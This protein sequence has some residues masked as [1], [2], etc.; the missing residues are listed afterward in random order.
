MAELKNLL[1]NGVERIN[2]DL[3]VS[4]NI[5]GTASNAVS[6][7]Y[8]PSSDVSTSYAGHFTPSGSTTK[9]VTAGQAVVGLVMDGKG[10]VTA[11]SGSSNFTA[12][13]ATSASKAVS[14]SY[15]TSASRAISASRADSAASATSATT[16][17][18]NADG[19]TAKSWIT[20]NSG[21]LNSATA[22]THTHSNKSVLDGIDSLK[23]TGWNDAYGQ[24]YGTQAHGS[25]LQAIYAKVGLQEC[26]PT[27]I[28]TVTDTRTAAGAAYK[29][30]T[31]DTTLTHGRVV[32]FITRYAGASNA[33]LELVSGSSTTGA[34]PVYF[35]G[36]TRLGTQYPANSLIFLVYDTASS[37][38]RVHADYNTNTTY[39][40]NV[41]GSA[42]NGYTT[43][44]NIPVYAKSASGSA[45]QEIMD[46]GISINDVALKSEI[47]AS[48]FIPGTGYNSAVLSGSDAEAIGWYSFAHG[49][50]TVMAVG[51]SSH[52]EGDY[53]L[54]KGIAAHAEGLGED[55]E[56]TSSA[57]IMA[58]G[59][60]SHAE[61]YSVDFTDNSFIEARG[62]GS[63]AE[64]VAKLGGQI[65]AGNSG[66]HAEGYSTDEAI[67]QTEGQGAHAG[68]YSF[69]TDSEIKAKG[70]GSFARGASVGGS[71]IASGSGT[72]A[73]GYADTSCSILAS[74]V[75]SQ[76]FGYA[77]NQF[78][79]GKIKALGAG[80]HAE[81]Y[82]LGDGTIQAIG[83]GAHA[84][85]CVESLQDGI[86]EAS[87]T[88]SHAEG[89]S[90]L[91]QN[92]AAHAEGYMTQATGRASHA[93]GNE[94]KASGSNS[95]AEGESS[96][97]KGRN[98]HVEGYSTSAEG[99]N[100]HAEGIST[101]AAGS[102][103]HAEGINRYGS[104][105]ILASGVASHV[106]GYAAGA[107]SST[108]N[109][110]GS[111]K[112]SGTGSHAGGIAL[113][114]SIEASGDGAFARGYVTYRNADNDYPAAKGIITASGIGSHAEGYAPGGLISATGNGAHA[115]GYSDIQLN[116][117]SIRAEGTGSHAEGQG[118]YAK[119]NHSHAEGQ[120]QAYGEF[121]HA[122]GVSTTYGIYSHAEGC[123]TEAS[124]NYSHAEGDW[125]VSTGH[126]SHAE[127]SN[128]VAS[129]NYSHAEGYSTHASGNYAHAEGHQT[130]AQGAY[131]HTQGFQTT[132]SGVYEFAA[133]KYNVAAANGNGQIFSIGVG[134]ANNA[135]LNAMSV[136]TSSVAASGSVKFNV[137]TAGPVVPVLDE[138]YDGDISPGD[139]DIVDVYLK[140]GVFYNLGYID[141]EEGGRVRI[142]R[143]VGPSVGGALIW[144]GVFY[145]SSPGISIEFG[146][147][148]SEEELLW[149]ENTPSLEPESFYEFSLMSDMGTTRGILVKWTA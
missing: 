15:A 7:A 59:N 142:N 132:A 26:T 115:E 86:T 141:G 138:S 53:T 45:P 122:E 110:T 46:S 29:G 126:Y 131:S 106:E 72:L 62:I 36:T 82:A 111:I 117:A 146:R 64:G 130:R 2:G 28:E 66:S 11:V 32:A 6:A 75:G 120:G 65:I 20:S 67:I 107:V 94:T 3:F 119:G 4:G 73:G 43:A 89:V 127:G 8:A 105:G 1:V 12:S 147:I 87:G 42:F 79:Q 97:A 22:S 140:P 34:K 99:D 77:R 91:A 121:S 103:S 96:T 27:L 81:G 149:P 61:G 133:G 109:F 135:R 30:N 24:I 10:H 14:A 93:E 116:N 139:T 60:G 108:T 25:Q 95:H 134:T 70:A 125:S 83:N 52:A 13:F 41:S 16:A 31:V 54:A 112:A 18:Y 145:L 102:G 39:A 85:G 101:K 23:V 44:S 104:S 114:G 58:T 71:L 80:A 55:Y 88:G 84:E 51:N 78:G 35:S 129:G 19:A 128:T 74:G 21:N 100:S 124:G 56:G 143:T 144:G 5:L 57:S 47:V 38:W 37:G 68:G 63:H 123:G 92:Y 49:G 113:S 136:Y 33:T 9:L 148:T 98:S 50:D 90:T 76:A 137:L 17:S 48:P 69:G 118:S 40:R